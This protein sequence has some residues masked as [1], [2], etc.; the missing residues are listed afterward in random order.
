LIGQTL[1][2]FR[3]TAKLGEGGMGAVYLA[4]DLSLKRE[5][6]LKI[7]PTHLA[8]DPDRL[9]RFQREAETLAA[10]SHPNIVGIYSIEQTDDLRFL[11]MERVVGE[12][13]QELI[14][15]E[16]LSP[17][18]FFDYAVPIADA[19]ATAH[20][21]GVVHRDLKPANVMVNE[22]G[23]VKVLDLGLAKLLEAPTGVDEEA[24]TQTA[25]PTALGVVMG[26]IGYMSPEQA[27]GAP[28]GP[29]SDVFSLGALFYEMLS[30]ENP[31]RRESMASSLAAILHHQPQSIRSGRH[32]LPRSLER[33]LQ[34]CL[35]KAP[36][37][38]FSTAGKLRESLVD[39]ANLYRRQHSGLRAVLRRPMVAIPATLLLV[40]GLLLSWRA[41]QDAEGRRWAREEAL[42]EIQR[43]VDENW[44]DFTRAYALAVEA[45]EHIP[46]D[47]RLVE[48]LSL[49]SRDVPVTTDPPGAN[50]DVRN[51][52]ST[53]QEWELLGVTPLEGVRLPIGILRWKFEKPGYETVLA[54]DATWD[55]RPGGRFLEANPISRVL[56]ELGSV[57]EDMVRV[58]GAET[59]A[60]QLE[61]FF[62]DRH[63]VTN[64]QFKAFIDAGGYRTEQY[65]QHPF[66]ENGVTLAREEAMSRFVDQTGRP[67]PPHWQAGT[68]PEGQADFPAS[69][70]SWYEAAAYAEFAGRALPTQL[71]W[72]LASGEATPVILFPQLGGNALFAPLS[73]FG[74][75]G[76]RAVGSQPNTVA[77]GSFDMPG[78][79]REWCFNET[80]GGR[81]VRGGSWTDT[82]YM[83][84]ESSHLSPMD[85]SPQNGFRCAYYP[86][87]E[88][89]PEGVFAKGSVIARRN[90]HEVPPVSDEVFEVYKERFAY[91]R[92]DLAARVEARK[93]DSEYWRRETV[94]YNAA[95]G[96]ERIIAH[97]FLPR[98]AS[99]PYQT[100]IY[101]PGVGSIV[102]PSSENIEEYFE[103][104]VFVSFLLQNGRAVLYPVYKG[105]FERQAPSLIALGP[106]IGANQY[107]EFLS[108]LVRDFRRSVDYLE[109]RED[110]DSD[111]FAYY[112]LS[113]GGAMGGIITAVEDRLAASVWLSGGAEARFTGA[114]LT[115]FKSEADPVA[116]LPRVKVPT[117]MLNGRYDM[118]FP[119]DTV[120][121]PTFDLLG[122]PPEHKKLLLYDTDHIPPRNEFIREI[123]SW[124]DEYL[125]PVRPLAESG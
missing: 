5:V 125:G 21:R 2:H 85:R 114:P 69:G 59:P 115:N 124:L 113:W 102:Q 22:E 33:I 54:T 6:A 9:A 8:T 65:W 14:P 12:S 27:E 57:P 39:C 64:R 72:G 73:N 52:F 49:T 87:P 120:I 103:V 89:I 32:D 70:V 93:E 68:Y 15:E 97:L 119:L 66:V 96:G 122:T 41:W 45:E 77:F 105:T 24:P 56:D 17:E 79:V 43:L 101:F 7:L 78:N 110:V 51:Y 13:L 71:H 3:I 16:G 30:G 37:E 121:R 28:V 90:I 92:T 83:F 74:S 106:Q 63:E 112:G 117:L 86:N 60:G 35:H 26:T 91:D 84:I 1:S 95:Y 111:R 4:E 47:P 104:P 50:V 53:S 44:R 20:A 76:P 118:D 62:I 10:L 34:R 123:L 19:M 81:I 108:Q 25:S 75:G 88:R 36:E 31:F 55:I 29:P 99:P 82:P 48:L 109:T 11:I 80:A 67:G 42:P 61:D 98:S 100:V 18:T 23:V 40:A 107:S 58:S 38:R 46:D 116:Y 94:T